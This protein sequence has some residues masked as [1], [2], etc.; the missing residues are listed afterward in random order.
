MLGS[1]SSLVLWACHVGRQSGFGTEKPSG[2]KMQV[3]AA[4]SYAHHGKGK[5]YGHSSPTSA[6]RGFK[7]Q[8]SMTLK[9]MLFAPGLTK[10]HILLIFVLGLLFSWTRSARSFQSGGLSSMQL[11]KETLGTSCT[12]FP[13]RLPQASPRVPFPLLHSACFKKASSF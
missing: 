12:K 11:R 1:A 2:E 7:P 5:D 8:P 13:S 6:T 10:T 3:L 4:W 9:L